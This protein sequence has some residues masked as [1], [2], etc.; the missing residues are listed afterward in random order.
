MVFLPEQ[1]SDNL[2]LALILLVKK[3]GIQIWQCTALHAT[4]I[5]TQN[6][7]QRPLQES[8]RLCR[9]LVLGYLEAA[10]SSP[11]LKFSNDGRTHMIGSISYDW[12]HQR[13]GFRLLLHRGYILPEV[14]CENRQQCKLCLAINHAFLTILVNIV[15]AATR[16]K[17]HLNFIY[18]LRKELS[19][20]FVLTKPQLALP[21]WCVIMCACC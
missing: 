11:V 8:I 2:K 4:W 16:L 3:A 12:E 19:T 14:T 10:A 6:S 1:L 17:V 7:K 9:L 13:S 5:L 21:Y 15:G 18:G 20:S